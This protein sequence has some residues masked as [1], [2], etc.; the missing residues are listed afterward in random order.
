MK[1]VVLFIIL[2]FLLIGC[3][4]TPQ[5]RPQL[6]ELMEAHPTTNQYDHHLAAAPDEGC[7][8]LKSKNIGPLF[9]VFNDLPEAHIPH[10]KAGGIKPIVSDEDAWVNG[11]NLVKIES[12]SHLFVDTLHHSYPF[13]RKHAA[14]LLEEIGKRFADSLAARGGGAYRLKVTSLLRTPRTVKALRRVNRNASAESAHSF[15]TTFDISYSKFI[16]DDATATHRT[17][18]DLKNLLAEI[19]YDLREEGRCKVKI[20]RHQA[21]MHIT[22]CKPSQSEYPYVRP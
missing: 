4:K 9:R 22:A 18:E 3:S 15:A 8:R 20:E 14:D 12:N 10:A 6:K 13:L 2:S 19:V 16:C 17:F 1:Q 11:R 7:V 21:C 5:I